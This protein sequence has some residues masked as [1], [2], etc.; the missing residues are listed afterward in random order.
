MRIL[1][2]G[3][4]PFD[5]DTIN[6]SALLVDSLAT[7]PPPGATLIPLILPC[8]FAPLHHTLQ[9]AL[10]THQP[11]ITISFGLAGNRQGISLE[12]V[13]LNIIDARIPDNEGNAPIDEPVLP[14]APAAYFATLPIKAA[15]AALHAAGIDAHISQTAGTYVCNAAAFTTMHLATTRYPTMRAGFIHIPY[16]PTMPAAQAGAPALDLTTLHRAASL[17]I[18]TCLE[19]NTDRRITGG[20]VS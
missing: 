6:P 20:T 12:R 2:T 10:E 9:T 1:I 17:I 8:A 5:G 14:N 3:F 11:A 13:A 16:L 7:T 15:M 18:K 4:E 19:C